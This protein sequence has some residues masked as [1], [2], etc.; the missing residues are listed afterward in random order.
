MLFEVYGS[1]VQWIESK[2][3]VL[4]IAVR[5]RSESHSRQGAIN[6]EFY[7]ANG[8]EKNRAWERLSLIIKESGMTV[9]AFAAHI[10]LQ[11]SET[12]YQIKR[13]QIGI[14]RNVAQ[15]VVDCFPD[16]SAMWLRS[17]VGTMY[18]C[19]SIERGYIPYYNCQLSQIADLGT[20]EAECYLYLPMVAPADFAIRYIGDDMLPNVMNGTYLIL[21]QVDIKS[22]IYGEIYVVRTDDFTVLRTVRSSAE[23]DEMRLVAYNNQKYD[24]MIIQR[25]DVLEIYSVKASINLKN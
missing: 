10:G 3:P 25:S 9:H 12:L 4:T 21:Q 18:A 7:M 17:G 23:G 24:D 16:Y 1:V 14:S 11:R 15:A 22:V 13:G 2:I 20:L 5:I 19:P 8:V 6:C